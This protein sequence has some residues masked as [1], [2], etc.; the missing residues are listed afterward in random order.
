VVTL[1]RESQLRSSV[2]EF[3]YSEIEQQLVTA[4]PEV[5]PAADYYWNTEGEPGQD[6]GPY[7]FFGDL[8][9]CY[10]EVLLA[11]EPSPRRDELLRRVFGVVERMLGSPDVRVRDLVTIGL[12]EGRDPWWFKRAAP[13][14]GPRGVAW[15]NK[16]QSCWRDRHAADDTVIPEIMD[17]YHVRAVIAQELYGAGVP[18]DGLPGRTY[19]CGALPDTPAHADER[20][21]RHNPS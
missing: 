14:V 12:Y 15:L 13:F 2:S 11:V 19:A 4:L 8:V 6:C 16:Y 1:P 9:A 20:R 17:G 5:R 7:I 10:V 18:A 21:R 3:R